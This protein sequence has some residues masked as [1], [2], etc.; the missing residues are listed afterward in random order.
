MQRYIPTNSTTATQ[1]WYR[2][3]YCPPAQSGH[4]IRR[5]Y[6]YFI[7]FGAAADHQRS[8]MP[9]LSFDDVRKIE[10]AINENPRLSTRNPEREL[11]ILRS[12]IRDILRK[13]LK[14]FPYKIS[15]LQELLSRDYIDRPNWTQHCRREIRRDS[16]Y[17]SRVV[18][19]DESLFIGTEL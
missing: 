11:V 15:F 16:Q 8:G 19:S 14:I 9:P 1:R 2:S 5:R 7:R 12:T 4:S 18:F 13:K 6:D 17:L 10:S 3:T